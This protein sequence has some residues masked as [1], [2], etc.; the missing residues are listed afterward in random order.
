MVDKGPETSDT[1]S[2]GGSSSIPSS[3]ARI[4]NSKASTEGHGADQLPEKPSPNR[5][6]LVRF[7]P[8]A[9]PWRKNST[10][11]STPIPRPPLSVVSSRKPEEPRTESESRLLNLLRSKSKVG[12]FHNLRL[13]KGAMPQISRSHTTI[14]EFISTNR[15]LRVRSGSL[16]NRN[17]SSTASSKQTNKTFIANVKQLLQNDKLLGTKA[18]ALRNNVESKLR[19]KDDP[20]TNKLRTIAVEG[21]RS[22]STEGK[23]EIKSVRSSSGKLAIVEKQQD[24]GKL[25]VSPIVKEND[26]LNKLPKKRPSDTAFHSKT[27]EKK[28]RI[29]TEVSNDLFKDVNKV[30]VTGGQNRDT[31]TVTSQKVVISAN[32]IGLRNRANVII[33]TEYQKPETSSLQGF[34]RGSGEALGLVQEQKENSDAELLRNKHNGL[35]IKDGGASAPKSPATMDAAGRDL[36]V[37]VVK[38]GDEPSNIEVRLKKDHKLDTSDEGPTNRSKPRSNAELMTVSSG[39]AVKAHNPSPGASQISPTIRA[40]RNERMRNSTADIANL[41]NAEQD[42]SV[43]RILTIKKSGEETPHVSTSDKD[44]KAQSLLYLDQPTKAFKDYIKETEGEPSVATSY[45]NAKSENSIS[46]SGD[47]KSSKGTQEMQ[48]KETTT[49][50]ADMASPTETPAQQL[51]S[52][53]VEIQPRELGSDE[54]SVKLQSVSSPINDKVLTKASIE[55]HEGTAA[56][57]HFEPAPAIKQDKNDSSRPVLDAEQNPFTD[58]EGAPGNIPESKKHQFNG[59]KR[60]DVTSELRKKWNLAVSQEIPDDTAQ[61]KKLVELFSVLKQEIVPKEPKEPQ[62]SSKGTTQ[63]DNAEIHGGPI[64]RILNVPEVQGHEPF[65]G[66]RVLKTRSKQHLLTETV[67][68]ADE[69]PPTFEK[70]PLASDDSSSKLELHYL[71]EPESSSSDDEE[72]LGGTFS[73]NPAKVT[74]SK[75]SPPSALSS[76]PVVS[77][78]KEATPRLDPI[79]ERRRINRQLAQDVLNKLPKGTSYAKDIICQLIEGGIV[80]HSAIASNFK[81]SVTNNVCSENNYEQSHVH[82]Y[83]QMHKRGDLEF[84]PLN[85][86]LSANFRDGIESSSSAHET[87]LSS[88]VLSKEGSNVSI[89][90]SSQLDKRDSLGHLRDS[91]KHTWLELIQGCLVYVDL[92]STSET[93]EDLVSADIL[94]RLKVAFA[95]FGAKIADHLN[96]NVSILVTSQSQK[97]SSASNASL[98]GDLRVWSVKKACQFLKNLGAEPI[99]LGLSPEADVIDSRTDRSK[100]SP[101]EEKHEKNVESTERE[102]PSSVTVPKTSEQVETEGLP[103]HAAVPEPLKFKSILVKHEQSVSPTESKKVKLTSKPST[104]ESDAR[105]GSKGLSHEASDKSSDHEIS[106]SEG[107]DDYESVQQIIQDATEALESK[108]RQIDAAKKLILALSREVMQKELSITSLTGRLIAA[109]QEIKQQKQTLDD[110]AV[111][112]VEKELEI[113]EKAERHDDGLD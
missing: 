81:V 54:K 95:N 49:H 78:D 34:S 15:S 62:I 35:R 32:E 108:D 19:E 106:D 2:P 42:P 97:F 37:K 102:Q 38:K 26:G 30:P 56:K 44:I 103:S 11:R 90:P 113:M 48:E 100:K 31:T 27:G 64:V 92:P 10:S 36:K 84:I 93:S 73:T 50:S 61:R 3:P 39:E 104:P 110:Y 45:L 99:E 9:S 68:A 69:E 8:S 52:Q 17:N 83:Q 7:T 89:L 21:K 13:G 85:G 47:T 101:T 109:E 16:D 71:T 63:N 94:L 23:D 41:L 86:P 43:A 57:C 82:Y 66:K 28:A 40:Q 22:G 87:T 77:S 59:L 53:R 33:T 76:R 25:S 72:P 12:N 14:P 4:I 67:V 74:E 80:P 111:A 58:S 5:I 29:E 6:P 91:W 24:A 96:D 75:L 70:K 1:L 65:D 107:I 46:T 18:A 112:L 51:T 79:I 20:P 88:S 105:V 98:N 60:P 55:V